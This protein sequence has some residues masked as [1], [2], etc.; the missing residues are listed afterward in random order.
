MSS[1]AIMSNKRKFYT[2]IVGVR[3]D[4]ATKRA[5]E[6]ISMK[7]CKPVPA[8]I[9]EILWMAVKP[10]SFYINDLLSTIAAKKLRVTT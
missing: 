9:R 1:I 10:D 3:L 4:K 7:E 8:I 5:L 2:E 6:K